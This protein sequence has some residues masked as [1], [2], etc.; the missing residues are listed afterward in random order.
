MSGILKPHYVFER[1]MDFTPGL[2]NPNHAQSKC[3]SEKSRKETSPGP[4]C[5]YVSR[6][7]H[8][9]GVGSDSVVLCQPKRRSSV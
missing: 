6:E 1:G 2:N 7:C 3:K 4:V 8:L 5:I 9:S